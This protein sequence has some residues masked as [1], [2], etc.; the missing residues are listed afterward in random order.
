MSTFRGKK[1]TT[2]EDYSVPI[3]GDHGNQISSQVNLKLTLR[4]SILIAVFVWSQ[5]IFK[6]VQLIPLHPVLRQRKTDMF[7]TKDLQACA[8]WFTTIHLQ[9]P[10]EIEALKKNR[11]S[12]LLS[13]LLVSKQETIPAAKEKIWDI[14][15]SK[16]TNFSFS[17]CIT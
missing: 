6:F 9:F 4:K 10:I 16:A 13:E 14:Y 3:S 17:T 8:H 15:L 1:Q 2:A 11:D 12:K 7:K 5:Q